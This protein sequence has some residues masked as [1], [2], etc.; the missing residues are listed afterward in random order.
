MGL[1]MNTSLQIAVLTHLLL[2]L[3]SYLQPFMLYLPG[4]GAC[5]F[6]NSL[7]VFFFWP[8]AKEFQKKTVELIN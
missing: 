7:I 2:I 6:A 8:G 4:H 1:I 3:R 5:Y